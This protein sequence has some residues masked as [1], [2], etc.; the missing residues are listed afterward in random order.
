MKKLSSLFLAFILLVS[1][2]LSCCATA[3]SSLSCDELVSLIENTVED[4]L[5][6]LDDEAAA[7]IEKVFDYDSYLENHDEIKAFYETVYTK[8][9]QLCSQMLLFSADYA[10][11]ILDSSKSY[12]DAYDELEDVYDLIYDDMGDEIY[13]RIYDGVLED[14]YDAFYDGALD[15]SDAAPYSDWSKTHSDEYKAWSSARSDTYKQWSRFRSDVYKFWSRIRS[16]IYKGKEDRALKK[17]ADFRADAQEQLEKFSL[18]SQTTPSTAAQTTPVSET[19]A[20]TPTVENSSGATVSPEFKKTM[21]S[22]EAFFDE[23]VAFL[24]DYSANPTSLTLLSKY[25]SFLQKYTE[26]ITALDSIDESE[27]SAADDAYYVEVTLRISQ[28]L[29]EVAQQMEKLA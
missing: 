4:S 17:I 7:L 10:Q 16:E 21:D 9:G 19:A 8:S 23:Y 27:L 12:N 25:A 24:K 1:L 13:N 6:A 11:A 28:K 2:P 26:T 20:T 29:L 5:T 22:Y 18:D 3:A 14:L 15:D